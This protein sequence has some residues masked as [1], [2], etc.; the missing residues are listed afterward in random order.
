[1]VGFPNLHLA[2]VRLIPNL[3]QPHHNPVRV[4]RW[5]APE[6]TLSGFID[7]RSLRTRIAD[8]LQKALDATARF[9]IATGQRTEPDKSGAYANRTDA[10]TKAVVKN[11]HMG[12]ANLT[13]RSHDKQLGVQIPYRAF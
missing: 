4:I 6:V 11:F 9:D 1:M 5:A 12:A 8:Q 7:D 10:A 3:D 13:R 2:R